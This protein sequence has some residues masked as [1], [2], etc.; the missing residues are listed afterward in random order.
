MTMTIRQPLPLLD[1]DI[2]RTF[3][4]I[5]EAGS[6][7][8]AADRVFR[9]PSAVSMQIKKLEEQLNA[10]LFLRDARSVTLT[11]SGETLLPYARR[12]LA[13]SNEAVG[14]FRM[15]EMK[16]VVRLGAPDDIGERFMPTILRRFAEVYP[17]IMVD[18]TVD[19]SSQLRRRLQEQRLDL[20]LVNTAPGMVSHDGEVIHTE[21]LVW[22]GAKCGTAHLREPLPVSIWEDG[23]CW[24]ADAL[25]RLDRDKRAYRIAYLSAHT[26]AQRAA[27]IADLA[28]A[29]LPRSYLTDDM[30]ALGA[31]QGL[32]DLGSFEVRLL[33][34]AETSDTICAVADS[35][36]F[37]F[38][39]MVGIAA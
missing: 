3:V 33:T 16:G 38:A 31:K 14:R 28:V 20:T 37:A 25:G 32:P 4:A 39:E 8:T 19:T 22:A 21:Q 30:T 15:P 17:A 11:E 27:V 36:R 35:V 1:N 23:C 2:L 29:P 7:T 12:M 9:T 34:G 10:T 13:L 26:M 6:F 18:L 5:A 24:R